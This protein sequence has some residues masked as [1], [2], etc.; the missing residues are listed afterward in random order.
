[1]RDD[2]RHD[3]FEHAERIAEGRAF[4]HAERLRSDHPQESVRRKRED[5]SPYEF[6][7]EHGK[8]RTHPREAPYER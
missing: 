8:A 4:R 6:P 3:A 7:R 2:G 5:G 1:M